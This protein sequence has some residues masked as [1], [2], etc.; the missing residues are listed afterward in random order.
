MMSDSTR[1]KF[2]VAVATWSAWRPAKY[3]PDLCLSV[4]TLECE[5]VWMARSRFETS[6]DGGPLE[7][8]AAERLPNPRSG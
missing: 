8:A 5:V 3:S 7:I 2:V 6:S 4:S 1:V